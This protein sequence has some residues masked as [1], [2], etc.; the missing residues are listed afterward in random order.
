MTLLWMNERYL[1]VSVSLRGKKAD[2]AGFSINMSK[3]KVSPAIIKP[4]QHIL[5]G[6][7]TTVVVPNKLKNC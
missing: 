6:S 1:I 7:L 2:M 5:Q 4:L 3:K